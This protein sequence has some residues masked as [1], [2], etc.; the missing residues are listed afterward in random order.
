M[1]KNPETAAGARTRKQAEANK[2]LLFG[3]IFAVLIVFLIAVI[4]AIEIYGESRSGATQNIPAN[5]AD[6]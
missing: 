6:R 2:S 5:A 3:V 1:D 4:A